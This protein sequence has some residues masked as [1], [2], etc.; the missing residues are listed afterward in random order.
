METTTTQTTAHAPLLSSAVYTAGGTFH[1]R[2]AMID[3]DSNPGDYTAIRSFALP[4]I[5]APGGGDDPPVLQKLKA[6]AMPARS[7]SGSRRPGSSP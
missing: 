4:A 2:V 3:A 6:N 7:R 1:W 5:P